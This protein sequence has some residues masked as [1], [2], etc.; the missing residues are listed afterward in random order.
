M[1]EGLA[2]KEKTGQDYPRASAGPW[3]GGPWSPGKAELEHESGSQP[4]VLPIFS[5]TGP[6]GGEGDGLFG[7][8][9]LTRVHETQDRSDQ[10]LPPALQ[11]LA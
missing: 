8:G 2:V 6:G 3:G 9:Q 11:V 1:C 7:T 10:V 4:P 5:H